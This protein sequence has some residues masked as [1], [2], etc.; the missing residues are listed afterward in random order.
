MSLLHGW[1]QPN[2]SKPEERFTDL[3][4]AP[5]DGRPAGER[6]I[7]RALRTPTFKAAVIAGA[8]LG[9][10]GALGLTQQ[11]KQIVLAACSVAIPYGYVVTN[12]E[13]SR[14][15]LESYP[16]L[17]TVVI[18]KSGRALSD[19][20]ILST[21]DEQYVRDIKA[22]GIMTIP[23]PFVVAAGWTGFNLVM[24]LPAL[25]EPVGEAIA[26]ALFVVPS[27][28][29]VARAAYARHQLRERQW[30]VTANPPP[31]RKEAPEPAGLSLAR[32]S[33]RASPG[34]SGR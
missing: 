6:P 14:L 15:R 4:G 13:I 33:V 19:P 2:Y 32:V 24:G 18:D 34:P 11:L 17:K 23:V 5:Y 25:N 1:F 21:V 27:V 31:L 20:T 12:R 10:T 22:M 7:R 16:S 26:A 30:T 8:L 28:V 3:D 9:A 29:R